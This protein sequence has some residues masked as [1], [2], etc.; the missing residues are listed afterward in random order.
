MKF[1][2]HGPAQAPSSGADVIST[3]NGV[4]DV[5]DKFGVGRDG[6]AEGGCS[7]VAR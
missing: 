4:D 7:L 6:R 5:V 1:R 3:A 2:H